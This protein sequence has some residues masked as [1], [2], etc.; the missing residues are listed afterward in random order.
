MADH[1]TIEDLRP[2][3]GDP[4]V[5]SGDPFSVLRA[6]T[7]LVNRGQKTRRAKLCFGRSS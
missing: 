6:I 2:V 4:E 5:V 7:A 1:L 3:L